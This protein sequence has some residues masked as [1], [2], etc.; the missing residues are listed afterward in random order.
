M[1]THGSYH[2]AHRICLFCI[3][4]LLVSPT[5]LWGQISSTTASVDGIVRNSAGEVLPNASVRIRDISTNQARRTISD[6]DGSYRISS[7]PV[8]SYEIRVE[9]PGFAVYVNPHV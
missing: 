8:S 6:A 2:L 3:L 1:E 9:S 4:F 7:L 5:A